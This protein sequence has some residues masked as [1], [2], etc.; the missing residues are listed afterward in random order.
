MSELPSVPELAAR[1]GANAKT[2]R[3][4]MRAQKWR[5]AVEHG[6][7]WTLTTDQVAIL[8]ARYGWSSSALPLDDSGQDTA[9]PEELPTPAPDPLTPLATLTV[10]DLLNSYAS[11]LAELRTRNL[12][13]TN[14]APIGDLAE[15]CA[16][17]VYDGVLAPN[18]E[19]AFDLTASD[20]RRVQVKV[21][22]TQPGGTKSAIFSPIRSFGFDVCVFVVI[23][24]ETN[25]VIAAREWSANEVR[26]HGSFRKHTNGTIVTMPRVLS[27]PAPGV[28]RVTDFSAAWLAMLSQ[29]R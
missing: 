18:S 5:S 6:Q 23:D 1:L 27:T 24:A 7:P 15:Y 14:N 21:R 29:T 11:V 26:E 4:W 10:A 13:R 12:I 28:D 8:T 2:I 3:A 17:T 25:R 19:K 20:G 16:A 9:Q 22:Q